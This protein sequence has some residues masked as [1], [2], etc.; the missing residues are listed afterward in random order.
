MRTMKTKSILFLSLLIS[1]FSI[2]QP[3]NVNI[4]T[5][6][7]P[8]TE[9]FIAVNPVNPNNLIA[10]WMHVNLNLKISINTKTKTVYRSGG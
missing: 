4:S 5:N 2:S 9:P 1:G 8:D 10:G 7:L 3:V 6:P